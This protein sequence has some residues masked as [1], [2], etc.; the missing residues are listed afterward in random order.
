[1]LAAISGRKAD[2]GRCAKQI[3]DLI[4]GPGQRFEKSPD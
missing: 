4:E 2:L 1:L 3:W